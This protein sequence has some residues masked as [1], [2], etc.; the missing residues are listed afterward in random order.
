MGGCWR[1]GALLWCAVAA[2][3]ALAEPPTDRA[4]DPLPTG[5]GLRLGTNRY[6]SDG[7]IRCLAISPDGKEIA[8]GSDGAIVFWD[9][10]TGRVVRRRPCT[11]AS[12]CLSLAYSRDGRWIAACGRPSGNGEAGL[13]IF[14]S[15]SGKPG[16]QFSLN[17]SVEV[18]QVV[19]SL[20]GAML[21]AGAGDRT[22]RLFSAISG[23]ELKIL[24]SPVVQGRQ[25]ASCVAFSPDGKFLAAG[26][27]GGEVRI[28][29]L[30]GMAEPLVWQVAPGANNEIESLVFSQDSSRL[31]AASFEYD[32]TSGQHLGHIRCFDPS[33]GAVQ[34]VGLDGHRALPGSIKL[35]VSNDRRRLAAVRYDRIEVWDFASGKRLMT[36]EDYQSGFLHWPQPAVFSLD[37]KVL[38][39]IDGRQQFVRRWDVAT[40]KELLDLPES[41]A[42]RI[43][44]LSFSED[45]QRIATTS[46]DQTT[47][48]WDATTGRPLRKLPGMMAAFSP[49]GELAATNR[50]WKY[51]TPDGVVRLIA[52]NSG[53]EVAQFDTGGEWIGPS[54][55][56]H[57][58]KL[59]AVASYRQSDDRLGPLL[60]NCKQQTIHLWDVA[61]RKIRLRLLADDSLLKELN[62]SG[63]DQKLYSVGEDASVAVWNLT[64]GKQESTEPIRPD[65]QGRLLAAAFSRNGSSLASALKPDRTT[66]VWLSVRDLTQWARAAEG[67][68]RP[69]GAWCVAISPDARRLALA[70]R[71]QVRLDDGAVQ[72]WDIARK[73]EIARLQTGDV[74]VNGLEFSPDGRRLA[75][76]MHDGTALVWDLDLLE[77]GDDGG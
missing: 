9:A 60:G 44:K 3:G 32:S 5:A 59:L 37:G 70:S 47:R 39:V 74:R 67:P 6:R 66:L 14:E 48:L 40:G 21:A 69:S 29:D 35:I 11:A 56:S 27:D 61:K 57:D 31:L 72:I 50:A 45:G 73:R 76:G 17:S 26:S 41:H 25:E 58:G 18:T 71:S 38:Y 30:G 55:F 64:T 34:E 62:F 68:R 65:A 54:V 75:A 51:V 77:G 43:E 1:Y 23:E 15:I 22:V 53:D 20:D 52:S 19:F 63:N 42:S 28:W 13:E 36:T 24:Q 2:R 7:H 16:P 33:T 49:D 8:G 46:E 10:T 12:M 4:G